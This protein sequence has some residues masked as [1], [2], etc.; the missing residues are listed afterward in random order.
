MF[1]GEKSLTLIKYKDYVIP[2][3]AT[4]FVNVCELIYPSVRLRV[5]ISVLGG[6][7]HDPGKF[8]LA[9]RIL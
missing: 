1:R 3:G 8:P 6:I 2:A 5:I 4:I 9:F 7:F